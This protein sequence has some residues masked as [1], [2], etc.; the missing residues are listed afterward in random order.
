MSNGVKRRRFS[1]IGVA[2]LALIVAGICALKNYNNAKLIDELNDKLESDIV[3]GDHKAQKNIILF[4]DYNCAYCKKFFKQVYPQL[5][6]EYIET[7]K[8]KLTLRLIC[9][10]ND[11][12][13]LL[14][15]QTAIC[16]NKF[17]NFSKLHQL[18]LHQSNIIYSNQFQDLVEGYISANEF[19]GEC[20]LNSNHND[21][22]RNIYQF[23]LL[24]K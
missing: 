2:C 17:G 12:N 20:I 7:G 6:K 3:L 16:I 21:V 1:L 19:L 5:E 4:F 9:S 13:A 14:A 22:I 15:N 10:G 8:A 11:E 23:Q 24:K 18:L